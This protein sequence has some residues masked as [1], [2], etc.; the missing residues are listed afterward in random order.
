MR[1]NRTRQPRAP[2]HR[3]RIG[4][5]VSA[6]EQITVTCTKQEDYTG[7]DDLDFYMD[8]SYLGRMTISTG[9][10]RTAVGPGLVIGDT[11]YTSPGSTLTVYENDLV[12]SSDLVLSH[13]VT[14][15]DLDAPCIRLQ[16]QITSAD[17]T[18][19]ICFV[20]F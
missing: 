12:D 7:S 3:T 17:Y 13:T 15:G 6:I 14:D 9:E 8:D 4:A 5:D 2:D 19:D 11:I 10:T 20:R 18:F 16:D 1:T